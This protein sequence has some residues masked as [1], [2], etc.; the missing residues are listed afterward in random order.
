MAKGNEKVLIKEANQVVLRAF[1]NMLQS[2]RERQIPHRQDFCD[3]FGLKVSNVAYIETGRFL[4]LDFS[5]LRTYLAAVFGKSDTKFATQ[6]QDFY[7]GQKSLKE[8]VKKI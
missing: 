6:A 3:K 5:H 7:N 4:E 2:C 1:G 8:F